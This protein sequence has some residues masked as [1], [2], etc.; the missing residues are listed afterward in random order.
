VTLA[1][2]FLTVQEAAT[3]LTVAAVLAPAKTALR[4]DVAVLAEALE[5]ETGALAALLNRYW[6]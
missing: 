5:R 6:V 1:A 4:A 3:Q 2:A